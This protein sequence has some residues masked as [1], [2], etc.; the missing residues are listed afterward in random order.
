[1]RKRQKLQ[2]FI[3]WLVCL[4][5]LSND[6]NAQTDSMS[7]ELTLSSDA[8]TNSSERIQ[9]RVGDTAGINTTR[10]AIVGGAALGTMVAVHVYQTNGWWKNNRRSFHFQ[11]D[12]KYGL[13][14]DKL[15]HF[16]SASLLTFL[17]SRSLQWAHFS[18]SSSLLWERELPHYSKPT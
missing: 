13:S 12:L 15:G 4:I 18:E 17:F 3:G 10:F 5:V 2:I 11:E 16:Y 8:G 7:T 14:V 1:M 9:L 6:L